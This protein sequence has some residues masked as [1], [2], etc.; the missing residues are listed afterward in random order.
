MIRVVHIWQKFTIMKKVKIKIMCL[1]C[2]FSI[3]C[4]GQ[5]CLLRVY[6]F[7]D[8]IE[9][10][11]FEQRPIITFVDDSLYLQT[12]RIKVQYP[13]YSIKKYTTHECSDDVNLREIIL[14]DDKTVAF[15]N[16]D[17]IDHCSLHY[18]RTF[19]GDNKWETLFLP[20]DINVSIFKDVF[21]FSS[22][23]N[24]RQYD[25]DND[26]VFDRMDLEFKV[27][28]NGILRAN[29]PYLIKAYVP[30]KYEMHFENAVLFPADIKQI[31]CS[32]I[33]Y[34]FIFSGCYSNSLGIEN[35]KYTLQKGKLLVCSNERP[36]RWYMCIKDRNG[37]D[38][39][40]NKI[41]VIEQGS[42]VNSIERKQSNDISAM[43]YSIAGWNV[44]LKNI[45]KQGV[46]II[47]KA[48]GSVKKVFLK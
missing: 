39:M 46:Y 38:V 20:F 22:I 31:D 27:I 26:G 48:D 17:F 19:L 41:S 25:D 2:F 44:D 8:S 7:D 37:D 43:I 10:Y 29:Y 6:S 9:S 5:S 35:N 15:Y 34:K 23:S 21:E 14:D 40:V 12:T 45:I 11:L 36:F 18:K 42:F 24:I 33:D 32:S 28:K 47:K 16:D 1:F 30:G 3:T 13:I 4:L